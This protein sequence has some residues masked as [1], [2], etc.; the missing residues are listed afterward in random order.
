[1]DE[2]IKNSKIFLLL[3]QLWFIWFADLERKKEMASSKNESH[4]Y[5]RSEGDALCFWCRKMLDRKLV[6]FSF[7]DGRYQIKQKLTAPKANFCKNTQMGFQSN[8]AFFWLL[9]ALGPILKHYELAAPTTVPVLY[10]RLCL[11]SVWIALFSQSI[12][13]SKSISYILFSRNSC[14]KT[15]SSIQLKS[16]FVLICSSFLLVMKTFYF[17]NFTDC[18]YLGTQMDV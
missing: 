10:H 13:C 4:K 6:F 3:Q 14:I 7:S 8:W 1:M 2:H 15:I 18:W 9:G 11:T 17:P 16:G 5:N 12:Y